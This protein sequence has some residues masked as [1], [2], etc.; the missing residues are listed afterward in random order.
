MQCGHIEDVV[1]DKEVRGKHL[2]KRYDDLHVS[3]NALWLSKIYISCPIVAS[4]AEALSDLWKETTD[5]AG[6]K[7]S[8]RSHCF[9]KSRRR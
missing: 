2:G 9:R 5:W 6:I 4:S 7:G 8:N 1:V 3:R